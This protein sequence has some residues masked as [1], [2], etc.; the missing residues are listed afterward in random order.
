M[1]VRLFVTENA[2]ARIEVY[3]NGDGIDSDE[4]EYIFDRYYKSKKNHKRNVVGS[5]IGLSIVK[6]ILTLHKARFGVETSKG[7]GSCFWFELK[8]S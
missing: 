1:S 5:G 2:C 3:D 4:L 7:T 8:M 6:Q